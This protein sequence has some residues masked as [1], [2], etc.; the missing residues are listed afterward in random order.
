MGKGQNEKKRNASEPILNV[1]CFKVVSLESCNVLH[2][3]YTSLTKKGK[4]V[5][6]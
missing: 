4:K 6:P 3:K 5:F 1:P 2:D